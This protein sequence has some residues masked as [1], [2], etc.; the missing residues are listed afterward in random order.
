MG[1]IISNL[2]AILYNNYDSGWLDFNYESIVFSP[3]NDTLKPKYR[4]VGKLVE[5]RGALKNNVEISSISTV[6]RVC[7]Y[8]PEGFYPSKPVYAVNQGSNNH[9]ILLGVLIDGTV[10]FQ[11]YSTNG[12]YPSLSIGRILTVDIQFFID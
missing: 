11:R 9:R 5:L 12:D 1:S 2:D 8:L 10:I 3:Y 4:K 7:G 6:S